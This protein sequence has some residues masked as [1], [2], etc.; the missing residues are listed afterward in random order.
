MNNAADRQENAVQNPAEGVALPPTP[1][2]RWVTDH[3]KSSYANFANANS[4]REEVVLNFGVNNSWDRAQ[5]EVAIELSH[6]IMLSPFAAKRL[7]TM[8][9]QL[10]AEYEQRYGEL[11]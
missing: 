2:V 8:L 9:A 11:N 4:T 1:R 10:I 3:L 7:S 5:A 6:R